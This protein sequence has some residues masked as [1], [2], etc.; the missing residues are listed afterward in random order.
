MICIPIVAKTNNEALKK[1]RESIPLSDIVELRIDY[2]E[3]I[4]LKK[5]LSP[6]RCT[7]IVTNRRGDEGGLFKGT[8][9]ARL[10]FLIEAVEMGTDYIDIELSTDDSLIEELRREIETRGN[11]TK[12]IISYHN[13]E[14]TPPV[15]VLQEIF[16][17]GVKRGANIVKIVTYARK[18]EDNLTIL[19]L[20]SHVRN[21]DEKII[22]FCMGEKGKV[23]RGM[24]PSFGSHMSFATL[25]KGLESAPGQLTIE[26][27]RTIGRILQK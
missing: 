25:E 8:E 1:M 5:L 19:N 4:N 12:L 11:Q 27:M 14:C 9:R 18:I 6:K 23:S 26:E 21:K 2:I 13:F 3:D 22:T 20:A 10:S 17:N 15:K 16:R 24:A 7:T